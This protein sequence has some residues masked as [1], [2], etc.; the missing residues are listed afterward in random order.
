MGSITKQR[1]H[2]IIFQILKGRDINSALSANEIH[3]LIMNE[4]IDINLRTIRRDLEVL[5]ESHGLSS[6]EGRPERYFPFKDFQFKYDLQLN[7]NTLQVLMI[8]LNNLKQTSH[9]YFVNLATEAETAIL[10]SLDTKV[11][12]EL[13]KSKRKY[14]FTYSTEGRP[15]SNNIKD[16][17]NLMLALR[18]NRTIHCKNNSPYKEE[19]YN[20]RVR[21]FAPYKFILNSGTP[22]LIVQDLE[23]GEFKNLRATR[24]SEV[25]VSNEIFTPEKEDNFIHLENQIGGWGGLNKDAVNIVITIDEGLAIYF[26][27]K[28]IHTSQKLKRIKDNI[29]ELK[30]KC[31]LSTELIRFFAGF[32][33]HIY[34]VKPKKLKD[35]ILE[36]YESKFD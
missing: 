34:S 30:L 9:E 3:S 26:K 29:Y 8:A 4:G 20:N 12:Q 22:Y 14:L 17:Q 31:A 6:D 10:N 11:A 16:F 33:E 2:E 27:E 7:E 24:I 28:S 36:I 5:S 35:Q 15:I 25:Q 32:G 13:R 18:E 19:V 21:H 23:D 1:R